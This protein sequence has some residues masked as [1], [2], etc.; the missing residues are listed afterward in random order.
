METTATGAAVDR[1]YDS[2]PPWWKDNG[3]S[4]PWRDN[5][6]A[7]LDQRAAEWRP[8]WFALLDRGV[9]YREI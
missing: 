8:E 4:G 1:R 9:A 7:E 2:W 6:R 3:Y 5:L